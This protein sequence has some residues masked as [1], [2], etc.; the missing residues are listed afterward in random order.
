MAG[1]KV[2]IIDDN[3]TILEMF[4][5]GLEKN[6]YEVV[7]AVDGT[8][9]MKMFQD[10]QPD[11]VIVDIAMPGVDGYQV[12]EEIREADEAADGHTPVVVLT[13]HQQ[14]AMRDY[15]KELG[16]DRY[17]TKPI[18]IGDFIKELNSLLED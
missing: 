16:V 13:A 17:L 7:I 2:L 1:G 15:A 12:I 4:E 5:I 11:I 10:E 8:L 6:G 3:K 14:N 9:G 18:T